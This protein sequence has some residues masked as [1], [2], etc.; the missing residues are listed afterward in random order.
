M[1]FVEWGSIFHS[2]TRA[3]RGSQPLSRRSGPCHFSAEPTPTTPLAENFEAFV[4]VTLDRILAL[5][6]EDPREL[7]LHKEVKVS[8]ESTKGILADG[9]LHRGK[10]N[11]V[12]RH[13]ALP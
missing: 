1:T 11:T 8:Q 3:P 12:R 5:S 4:V 7:F 9:D 6:L 2:H 10:Y 13:N